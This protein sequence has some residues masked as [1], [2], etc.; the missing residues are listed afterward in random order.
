M[1]KAAKKSDTPAP[2]ASRD[3]VD[4][5][6]KMCRL[7]EVERRNFLDNDWRHYSKL[8]P[9]Q[10]FIHLINVRFS[11]P[12][13]LTRIMK[14]TGMTSAGASIFVEKM[15]KGRIFEREAD[16]QDRRNVVIK[17]TPRAAAAMAS[18][19]DRLNRF[20]YHFFTD[21]TPQELETLQSACELVCRKL[22]Q[23]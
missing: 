12:C 9:Q 13:N 16:P 22:E 10:Q 19:D 18:L 1:T 20:I 11:L 21:C 6:K 23:K 8:I 3:R 15:V 7:L 14:I 5:L 2:V 4:I 17:F